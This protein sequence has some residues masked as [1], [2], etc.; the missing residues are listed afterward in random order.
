MLLGA[1][2][3]AVRRPEIGG[4]D[5]YV[6]GA[7][8]ILTDALER[9]RQAGATY[10]LRPITTKRLIDQFMAGASHRLGTI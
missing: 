3:E 6:T 4:Y 9:I 10:R 8:H 2:D 1:I 5:V 7:D